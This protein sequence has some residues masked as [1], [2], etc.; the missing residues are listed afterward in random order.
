MPVTRPARP[1]RFMNFWFEFHC[2]YR[3]CFCPNSTR[4]PHLTDAFDCG[5]FPDASTGGGRGGRLP[6]VD[7]TCGQATSRQLNRASFV[8]ASTSLQRL[9]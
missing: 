9:R 1:D 4:Y 2:R 7:K 8:A 5:R 3:G 6:P